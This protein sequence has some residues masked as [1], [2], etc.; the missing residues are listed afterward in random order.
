VSVKLRP[1]IDPL[2][3][4]Q[5]RFQVLTAASIKLTVFWDVAPC[6]P[7]ETDRRFRGAYCLWAALMMEAVSTSETSV[8]FYETTRSNIPEDS[9]L[10][11]PDDTWVNMEQRWNNIDRGKPE[12]S[13]NNCYRETLT[14]TNTTWTA[15]GANLGLYG[16]KQATNRLCYGTAFFIP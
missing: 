7:V 14:T 9:H 10:H 4:P 2:S 3:N 12:N 15:L 11:P 1:L 16:E 6:S 5:M 13:E 8:N